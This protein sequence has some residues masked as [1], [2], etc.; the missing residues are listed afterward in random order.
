MTMDDR[1]DTFYL[2][3]LR[4]LA[5]TPSLSQ[6]QLAGVLGA[7]LGKVNYSLRN[8]IARGW[9]KV[10]R[11]RLHEKK[12]IVAYLLTPIGQEAKTHLTAGYL[13]NKKME[14][15]ALRREIESLHTELGT[16]P[17]LRL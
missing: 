5:E 12:Y 2:Y 15:E 9:I 1:D 16:K 8:L 7:S 13:A 17:G 4:T 10:G 3:L 6:R 14:F 11:L